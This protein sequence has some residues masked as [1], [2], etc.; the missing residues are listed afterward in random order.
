MFDFY[1]L[2]CIFTLEAFSFAAFTIVVENKVLVTTD[3]SILTYSFPMHPF[4]TP[5]KHQ[6]TSDVFRG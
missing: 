6:K 5:W 2:S 1:K 4:T 3:I